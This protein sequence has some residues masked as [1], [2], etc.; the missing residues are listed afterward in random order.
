VNI[1]GK[2]EKGF[3]GPIWVISNLPPEEALE[4]YAKRMKIDESFR[5]LKNLLDLEKIMNRKQINMEK[6][7]AL[8]LLA[9]TIGFL[10]GEGLRDRMYEG[11][12]WCQYSGLFI[13]LKQK[14]QL[15]RKVF[16]EIMDNVYLLFMRILLGNVRTHIRSSAETTLT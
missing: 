3:S 6:M 10:L 2:W 8:V 9:Y 14:I 16:A 5:D 12:K 7:I 11:R 4:I 15:N 1:S 13:L